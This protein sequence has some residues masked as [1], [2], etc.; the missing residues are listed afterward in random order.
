MIT[1]THVKKNI[2]K[3]LEHTEKSTMVLPSSLGITVP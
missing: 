2:E 1:V 3:R